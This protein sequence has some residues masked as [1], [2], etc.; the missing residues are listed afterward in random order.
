MEVV[1]DI[2]FLEALILDGHSRAAVECTQSLGRAG[3]AVAVSSEL[4]DAIAFESRY[5]RMKLAQPAVLPAEDFLKWLRA[6]DAIHH[7]RLIIPTT[8]NSLLALLQIPEQ[9]SMRAR[10]V[11]PSNHALQVALD[12]NRTLELAARLQVPAPSTRVIANSS[13]VGRVDSFPVVLKPASSKVSDGK[14]VWSFEPAIVH[15]EHTR[16]TLL[17]GWL[18]QVA[19]LEQEYVQGWGV[20]I[21][22]LYQAGRMVWYLAH[23]RLHEWPLTGGASTYRKAIEPPPGM[24]EA[25][26]RLFDELQWNGVGM[27]EFKQ[28]KDGSYAL[29]EINPRLWGSLALSIDAGV[30]FPVGLWKVATGQMLPPQPDYR[31]GMR[32][33]NMNL[34][35]RWIAANLRA[36][37]N[38]PSLLLRPRILSLLELGLVFLNRERWDHFQWTDP[39]PAVSSLWKATRGMARIVRRRLQIRSML[40][41]RKAIVRGSAEHLLTIRASREPVVLFVCLGNICRSSFAELAAREHLSGCRIESAGFDR[42]PGRQTPATVVEAAGR[43]GFPMAGWRSKTLTEEHVRRADLIFVMDLDQFDRIGALYPGCRARVVL[44][45]LFADSPTVAIDDP[46][47]KDGATADRVIQQIL[48]AVHA[49]SVGLKARSP[50]KGKQLTGEAA[51]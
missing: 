4:P 16:Q 6:L 38:N 45:G 21:E 1:T 9:D 22:M 23:E 42:R 25:A 28:R 41:R 40:R 48:S 35:L 26:V 17:K 3:I 13:E 33:R 46:D 30:D 44:L 12:K 15:D 34:D 14:M 31:R 27:V 24:L 11:L 29:M 10:A 39:K 51:T 32:T 43:E 36:D 37:R 19:V 5:A 47:R 49:L 8:E 7:F 18:P 20:G 50:S 2:V